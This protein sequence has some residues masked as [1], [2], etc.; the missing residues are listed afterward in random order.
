[1][2]QPLTN[3]RLDKVPLALMESFFLQCPLQSLAQVTKI[4]AHDLWVLQIP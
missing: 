1:M 2:F 3:G 4:Q